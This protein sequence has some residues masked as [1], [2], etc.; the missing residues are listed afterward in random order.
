[1]IEVIPSVIDL[2]DPADK[3]KARKAAEFKA[4]LKVGG[5]FKSALGGMGMAVGGFQV[6]LH[7]NKE[8]KP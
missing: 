3:D 1:M 4:K 2:T 5:A 7:R 8:T 6:G